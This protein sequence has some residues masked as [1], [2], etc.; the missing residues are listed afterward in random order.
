MTVGGGGDIL[1]R[2]VFLRLGIFYAVV[3]DVWH[4][5]FQRGAVVGSGNVFLTVCVDGETTIAEDVRRC[6]S[7]FSL[8]AVTHDINLRFLALGPGVYP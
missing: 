1:R 3:L 6:V 7:L 5:L 2:V 4:E 8:Q